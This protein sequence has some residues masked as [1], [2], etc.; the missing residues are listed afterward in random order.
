MNYLIGLIATISAFVSPLHQKDLERI[1][2]LNQRSEYFLNVNRDSVCHIAARVY[3]Y[4]IDRFPKEKVKNLLMLGMCQKYGGG[5]DSAYALFTQAKFLAEELI[6]KKE[7]G[8]SHWYSGK[9]LFETNEV[10]KARPLYTKAEKIL[11]DAAEFELQF[12][13]LN[14]LA[15]LEQKQGNLALSLEYHMKV[16]EII[17]RENFQDFKLRT[18]ANIADIY[19]QLGN[20]AKGL[21]FNAKSLLVK[22]TSSYKGH[23]VSGM[24]QRASLF[25]GASHSDSSLYFFQR[26]LHLCQEFE[27]AED[28]VHFNIGLYHNKIGD[29]QRAIKNFRKAIDLGKAVV[30]VSDYCIAASRSYLRLN[31]YDSALYFA[32]K[33]YELAKKGSLKQKISESSKIL[34]DIFKANGDMTTA[35]RFLYEYAV[36]RDSVF[37]GADSRR[38]TEMQVKIETIDRRHEIELLKAKAELESFRRL[39]ILRGG[40]LLVFLLVVVIAL[41]V[42]RYKQKTKAQQYKAASLKNEI[43]KG[44][45]DL[46]SQSLHLIRVN[47]NVLEIEEK[48]KELKPKVQGHSMEVQR[49]IN[50]IRVNKSQEKDWENFNNYFNGLNSGFTDRL[51]D[52]FPS[53]TINEIRLC[54]L[55]KMN[56]LNGEIASILNVETRS[57]TMSKYRLKKKLNLQEDVDLSKFL[58][59]FETFSEVE[60]RY[61]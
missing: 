4:E 51:R 52:E 43:E 2:E 44:R 40:S 7:L 25:E 61:A 34:A 30:Q 26:A 29:N 53:L 33:G 24:V 3:R 15:Y 38:L 59:S 11:Q 16:L 22:D 13:V 42:T 49:L 10:E 47:N 60:K 50:T 54:A 12:K 32:E 21:E 6:M 45:H 36:Y 28:F 14:G 31:R 57:V 35:N 56:L 20:R 18:Y 37:M 39:I 23:L 27:L 48:L 58:S 46:H 41:I 5:M 9:V 1:Q 19:L 17:D 55:L 8:I